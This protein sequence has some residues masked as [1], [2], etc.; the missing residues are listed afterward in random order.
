MSALNYITEYLTPT[1]PPIQS[2]KLILVHVLH[3]AS[4]IKTEYKTSCKIKGKRIRECIIYIL[5]Y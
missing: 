2:I 5:R 3:F 4:R 1:L